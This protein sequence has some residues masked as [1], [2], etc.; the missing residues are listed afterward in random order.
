MESL[1]EEISLKAMEIIEQVESMGGMTSYILSG[2]AKRRIEV[3]SLYVYILCTF[4]LSSWMMKFDHDDCL[5]RNQQ[6]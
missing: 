5:F 1:T 2:L 4:S 6:R 3:S